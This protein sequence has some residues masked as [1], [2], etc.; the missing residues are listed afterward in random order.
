MRYDGLFLEGVRIP[1]R[2]SLILVFTAGA[3]LTVAVAELARAGIVAALEPRGHRLDRWRRVWFHPERELA[4]FLE[5]FLILAF[6]ANFV[7]RS[8]L[9]AWT[10]PLLVG[11]WALHLPADC[12]SWLRTR[13]RPHGTR[14]LHERGFLLLDLGPLWLRVVEV[15]LAAGLY[16]LLPP[17]RALLDTMMGFI[18]ASLQRWLS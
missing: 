13:R 15:G 8:A 6:V 2:L 7:A 1:A 10:T 16:L 17:L 12:W 4:F 3:L 14:Q 9:P 5:A 18:L 11:L